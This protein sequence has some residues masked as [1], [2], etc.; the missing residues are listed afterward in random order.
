[1]VKI[2]KT[3]KRTPV[4]D[5]HVKNNHNFLANG[6]I[7]HNCTE[8]IEPVSSGKYKTI[9]LEDLKN[10]HNP[11][12]SEING[13]EV[14]IIEGAETAVCLAEGTKILTKDGYINIEDCNDKEIY[15]PFQSDETIIP[16]NRFI[17]GKLI[18]NGIQDIYKINL[19]N[20]ID[21]K[22]T[23]NH[24]FLIKIKNGKRYDYVWKSVEELEIGDK[25]YLNISKPLQDT[26]IIE[27][28]EY[29]SLGWIIGDGWQLP[30]GTYG[31]CFSDKE[32]YAKEYVMD[33]IKSWYNNSPITKNSSHLTI[34]P[35]IKDGN[36]VWCWQTQRKGY[37]SFLNET[38]GIIP[39]KA[40]LKK[41]PDAVLNGTFQQKAN[42]LSGLFS[43][44]GTCGVDKNKKSF[45]FGLSS[46]SL[47]L[48]RQ[49]RLLLKEF[50]IDVRLKWNLVKG[51]NRWQGS[52]GT[53][54]KESVDNFFKYIGFKLSPEK[55]NR[56]NSYIDDRKYSIYKDYLEVRSIESYGTSKVYDLSI[57]EA[58][59][60]IAEGLVTHN[61]NLGSI[62]ISHYVKDG[63][64]DKI[65]LRNN[66]N[67][68]VIFLD[69]VIDINFY[70]IREAEISNKALRPIGLGLMG[71]QDFFFKLKLPFESEEAKKLAQEIQEEIYYQALKTSNQLA[72]DLGP[73][74]GW[75]H[76]HAAKG[77]LQ[78]DLA[79]YDEPNS[80]K[81]WQEL[82]E[83]IKQYGLRNSLLIAIAPTVTISAIT[84]ANECIEPQISNMFKRETLS[85][86][87]VT[88][89]KY[90][91]EDLKKINLWNEDIRQ[92]IKLYDGSIQNI[93]EIPSELKEIYKTVWE[94]KQ[95]ALIDMA[96]AR[97][98]FI[99]QSQSLNLFMESP[100]I[101]KLSSMY[102]Y[103]WKGNGT[104]E[105]PNGLKTT[106]YLRTKAATKI[107][108]TTINNNVI[109]ERKID[110][111]CE[112]CT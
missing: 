14:T 89:N 79:G 42:F 93:N 40:P 53:S 45:G 112:S 83:S 22:A 72:K 1:M 64:L 73:H 70:P 29:L 109:I 90:L 91:V 56:Y 15:V 104:L 33:Q 11:I 20:H 37:I 51:R 28:K 16:N 105:N 61:C 8:I 95:K 23:R 5:I 4:Y 87:F 10:Y 57:P 63:K 18:D 48:L 7:I 68:A 59:H 62:N 106:Y 54:H 55:Q 78:F 103:A 94:I 32:E 41:I 49:V 34:P 6:A 98:Y 39:N 99:D 9:K 12:I 84:A 86:E 92:K 85:G 31:V 43:A 66:V 77:L 25:F 96:I 30:S 38:F 13:D 47:T 97:G 58:H 60:F 81:R 75:E 17:K 108:K 67:L 26:S 111:P 100:T 52:L 69:R 76:T 82:K 27:D 50:G 110:E 19:S 74:T 2:T 35:V 46:S 21:I 3:G 44:D 80:Q 65:K 107:N 71:L 24:K 101:E 88:I 102:F 36:G